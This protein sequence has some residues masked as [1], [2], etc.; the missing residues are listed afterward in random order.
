MGRDAP[1]LPPGHCIVPGP[2]VQAGRPDRHPQNPTSRQLSCGL[3]CSQNPP[4]SPS[5]SPYGRS[6]S[7]RRYAPPLHSSAQY[8][9]IA[10]IHLHARVYAAGHGGDE[11]LQHG[12][13]ATI[14]PQNVIPDPHPERLLALPPGGL[15]ARQAQV[16]WW[17]GRAATCTK[18]N[19]ESS[20]RCITRCPPYTG[21][22]QAGRQIA[23][24]QRCKASQAAS[25]NPPRTLLRGGA[26]RR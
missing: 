1:W 20:A 16:P 10:P 18:P 19:I 21:A 3:W 11:P 23:V 14:Q 4:S 9:V 13:A 8:G 6:L 25:Q 5:P 22:L 2:K 12:A 26:W 7:R 17:T 24:N 15:R